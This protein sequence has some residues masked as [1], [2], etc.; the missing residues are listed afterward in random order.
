MSIFRKLTSRFKRDGSGSRRHIRH[1][2]FMPAR[3]YFLDHGFHIDGFINEISQGGAR[4]RSEQNFIMQRSNE[5]VRI[6]T[7]G[8]DYDGILRNTSVDGYGIQLRQ[9]LDEAALAAILI[10][11][12]PRRQIAA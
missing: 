8:F 1:E 7:D 5:I 9:P 3:L 12:P 6:C 10:E 11:N 4:F 2:C